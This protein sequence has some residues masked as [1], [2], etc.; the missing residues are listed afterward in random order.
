MTPERT[1]AWIG[2][3]LTG[4]RVDLG[5]AELKAGVC[6]LGQQA[7]QLA[8]VVAFSLNEAGLKPL[9][10][11]T[12]G[13]ATARV[14]GVIKAYSLPCFLYDAM[15]I[16][17][18]NPSFHAQYIAGAY[19]VAL[20]LSFDQEAALSAVCQQLALED[21]VASPLA[22]AE[23][24]GDGESA[25][26]AARRLK[27][28]LNALTSL[29]VVGE[30]GA[31]CGILSGSALLDL[32]DSMTPEVA[33]LAAGLVIAKLIS[34]GRSEHATL[35]GAVVL[36]QANRLFRDRPIFRQNLRLL[37]AFVSSGI[38]RVLASDVKYG[39]DPRFLETAPVR[40]LS[41]DAWNNPKSEGALAPGMFALL[42]AEQGSEE[43]F[44]PRSVEP[45][46]GE[47]QRGEGA[48]KD[49]V[50]LTREILDAI[51]TFGNSTRQSLVSFLS[52]GDGIEKAEREVDRL[53]A[54]GYIQ[55]AS[56]R[57]RGDSPHAVLKLTPKGER[58][59]REGA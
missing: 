57:V 34:M 25:G 18:T 36:L 59:L 48:R 35:P 39:L 5:A 47:V 4:G 19:A 15:K 42:N 23:R 26:G 54:E 44:V 31:I 43:F 51:S 6:I 2:H 33:E 38:G 16:D 53:L 50:P 8:S 1:E 3:S 10:L 52:T 45:S 37:S 13:Y 46:S 14:S 27:G 49:S 28:R 29:S 22:L 20:D 32:R 55:T 24:M 30:E 40:I 12:E 7:N 11:D 17:N 21:G 56:K 9:V 58:Y 41:S